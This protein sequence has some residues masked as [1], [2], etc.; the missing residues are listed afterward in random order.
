VRGYAQHVTSQLLGERPE[1]AREEV[2][3]SRQFPQF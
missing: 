1:R 3:G 2:L